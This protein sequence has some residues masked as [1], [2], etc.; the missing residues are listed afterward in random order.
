MDNAVKAGIITADNLSTY[1]PQ[2]LQ[3]IGVNLVPNFVQRDLTRALELS[4]AFYT[5]PDELGA[6]NVPENLLNVL[7]E[8]PA[9]D[10][11]KIISNALTQSLAVVNAK[12]QIQKQKKKTRIHY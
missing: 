9:Q 2:L 8:M 6:T 1:G 4:E 12:Q 11:E 7:R 3:D 10:A 5:A